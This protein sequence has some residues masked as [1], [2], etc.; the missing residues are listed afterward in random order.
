MVGG[1]GLWAAERQE[2]VCEELACGPGVCLLDGTAD[3]GFLWATLALG[4]PHHG[5]YVTYPWVTEGVSV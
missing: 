1:E 5:G 4:R 3:A 2:G